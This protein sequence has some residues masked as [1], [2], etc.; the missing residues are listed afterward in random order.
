[1]TTHPS[2]IA[3]LAHNHVVHEQDQECSDDRNHEARDTES[4]DVP[5]KQAG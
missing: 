3:L 1:M 2:Q 4:V 5:A